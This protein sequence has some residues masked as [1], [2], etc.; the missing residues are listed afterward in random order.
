MPEIARFYG[1]V[2]IIRLR[3]HNPP[4]FHVRYAGDEASYAI[5]PIRL[6][7]GGLPP[8]AERMVLE[9]AAFHQEELLDNWLRAQNRRPVRRIDPLT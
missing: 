8:R 3:E 1:M 5:R 4:H 7:K 2:V 9:W 6:L